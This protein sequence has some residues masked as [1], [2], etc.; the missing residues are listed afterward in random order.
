MRRSSGCATPARCGGAGHSAVELS[1]LILHCVAD[2]GLGGVDAQRSTCRSQMVS[3]GHGGPGSGLSQASSAETGK[4]LQLLR[5][6]YPLALIEE[7]AILRLILAIVLGGVWGFEGLL[8]DTLAGLRTQMLV[9]ERRCCS[10][11][12]RSSS[13]RTLARCSLPCC[14]RAKRPLADRLADRDR[15]RIRPGRT[16]PTRPGSG[17]R[18]TPAGTATSQ[19]PAGSW[20]WVMS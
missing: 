4:P 20:V 8:R 1:C 7:E 11:S 19:L 17:S 13:P 18:L 2:A 10:Q 3:P 12:V 9:V 5:D 6:R 15:C 14:S 16:D